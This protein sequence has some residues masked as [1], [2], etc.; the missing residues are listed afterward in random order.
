M[1][2][3]DSPESKRK[4]MVFGLKAHI[5]VDTKTGLTQSLSTTAANIHYSDRKSTS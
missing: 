3:R 1:R 4:A 5:D 2:S